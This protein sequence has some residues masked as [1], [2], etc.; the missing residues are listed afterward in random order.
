MTPPQVRDYIR[1][2]SSEDANGCWR[3]Q[4]ALRGGGYGVATPGAGTRSAHRASYQAFVGDIPQGLT[5]DHLCG[6]KDCVNPTHLEPVPLAENI[7]RAGNARTR[8]TQGW[9]VELREQGRSITWLAE[10]V[11]RPRR[12]LYGYSQ[13]HARPTPDFLAAASR[14]LGVE[15]TA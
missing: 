7:R 2:R 11:G 3:W 8:S 1:S 9:V 5:L 6:V 4:L 13:G 12:S 15:V 10:Q 14:A